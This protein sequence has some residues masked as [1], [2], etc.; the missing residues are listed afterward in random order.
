MVPPA[1]DGGP[2]LSLAVGSSAGA[3]RGS[4]ALA[5]RGPPL[6]PAV[7]P[8]LALDETPPLSLAGVQPLPLDEGPPLTPARGLPPTLAVGSSA[9][10]R[11]GV[12]RWRSTTVIRPNRAL[13]WRG[14][15]LRAD[16]GGG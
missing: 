13:R 12:Y 2:P 14:S 16:L 10:A 6:P 8:M 7:R 1:L 9:R 4:T 5:R 15:G 11:R 3:R